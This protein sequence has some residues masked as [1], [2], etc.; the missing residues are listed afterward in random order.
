[1]V[2]AQNISF[3]NGGAKYLSSQTN[4]VETN[5]TYHLKESFNKELRV[6]GSPGSVCVCGGGVRVF[7]FLIAE[8]KLVF[9]VFFCLFGCCRGLGLLGWT[10]FLGK[11]LSP[12][13]LPCLCQSTSIVYFHKSTGIVKYKLTIM[14]TECVI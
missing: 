11:I 9:L 4:G 2:L 13:L 5:I 14:S 7:P 8:P 10:P 1:M 3:P 6:Q 12:S